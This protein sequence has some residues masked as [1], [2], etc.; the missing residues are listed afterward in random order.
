MHTTAHIYAHSASWR[1][2]LQTM[3]TLFAPYFEPWVDN[4]EE[5]EGLGSY[6]WN[7]APYNQTRAKSLG[8]K[9]N[10]DLSGTWMGTRQKGTH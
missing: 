3:T 7:Q 8:F 9:T 4:A 5:F 1:P 10:W 6:S 2:A